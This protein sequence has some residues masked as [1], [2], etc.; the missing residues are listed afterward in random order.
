MSQYSKI[1]AAPIVGALVLGT[2]QATIVV[3]P[4]GIKTMHSAIADARYVLGPAGAYGSVQLVRNE[5]SSTEVVDVI[6]YYQ[7]KSGSS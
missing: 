4:G 6:A 1:L 7:G 3:T 2:G 5:M